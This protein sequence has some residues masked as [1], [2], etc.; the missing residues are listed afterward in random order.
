MTDTA[1]NIKTTTQSGRLAR[2]LFDKHEQPSPIPVFN[3]LKT[4]ASAPQWNGI[5]SLA[6]RALYGGN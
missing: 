2:S 4:P 6:F 3:K 1:A 5:H